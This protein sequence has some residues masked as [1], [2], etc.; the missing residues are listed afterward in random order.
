[1]TGGVRTDVFIVSLHS[2]T[3]LFLHIARLVFGGVIGSPL[4]TL[5]L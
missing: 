4:I 5:D 3:V 1:M 2:L